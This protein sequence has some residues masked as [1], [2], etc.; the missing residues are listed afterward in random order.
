MKKRS[1]ERY[2]EIDK[3]NL[4]LESKDISMA[5]SDPGISLDRILNDQDNSISLNPL[6]LPGLSK[7]IQETLT[8]RYHLFYFIIYTF[9]SLSFHYLINQNLSLP[10]M[11][12]IFHIPQVQKYCNGNYTNYD[13]KL[14]TPPGLYLLTLP[15]AY[16]FNCNIMSLR[17]FNVILG[18][19]LYFIIA[20]LLKTIDYQFNIKNKEAE[21]NDKL[22]SLITFTISLFPINFF[23]HHLYYTDTLSTIIIL[24]SFLLSLYNYHWW[25]NLLGLLSLTVRQTNIIW[26]LFIMIFAICLEVNKLDNN[27]IVKENK[28]KDKEGVTKLLLNKPSEFFKDG[29]KILVLFLIFLIFLITNDRKIQLLPKVIEMLKQNFIN[30]CFNVILPYSLILFSFASFILWNKGIV[31]GDKSNHIPTLH[32]TQLFYFLTFTSTLLW[33][34]LLTSLS[35]SSI[36]N[37][38]SQYIRSFFKSFKIMLLN[39]ISLF[40]ILLI[41]HKFTIHHPF[42]LSD[43]RHISFYIWKNLFRYHPLLPYLYA[44]LYHFLIYSWYQTQYLPSTKPFL[45]WFGYFCTISLSLIPSPLLELRYFILPFLFLR[46]VLLQN[47]RRLNWYKVI[48]ELTMYLISNLCI[49]YLFLFKPFYWPSEPGILQRFMW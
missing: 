24:L 35:M 14:T 28:N 41:I 49:A 13:P 16:I 34:Y 10:Y 47:K 46:I 2:G 17:L 43:N 6:S 45:L 30:L 15:F 36:L 18:L 25:N 38:F 3:T 19:K 8:N 48:T 7:V 23:Y 22:L 21:K 42:L 39:L 33:P 9:L 29:G 37:H 44:P 26:M 4:L 31:L 11:D 27:K 1:K 12:E 40:V 20:V 5:Y 32:F